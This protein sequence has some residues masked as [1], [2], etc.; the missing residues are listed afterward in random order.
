VGLPTGKPASGESAERKFRKEANERKKKLSYKIKWEEWNQQKKH[1]ALPTSKAA[2]FSF[3]LLCLNGEL[4]F[5]IY[6]H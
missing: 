5:R 2:L 6:A 3:L 1:Q 4:C